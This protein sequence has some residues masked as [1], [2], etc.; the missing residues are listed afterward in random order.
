MRWD[1]RMV[2]FATIAL[3]SCWRLSECTGGVPHVIGSAVGELL[4][5]S[6]SLR[7]CAVLCCNLESGLLRYGAKLIYPVYH[8]SRIPPT[9][10]R[11]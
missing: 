8:T 10:P 6:M 2:R 3:A 7:V 9:D 11:W 4:C 5:V 1:V